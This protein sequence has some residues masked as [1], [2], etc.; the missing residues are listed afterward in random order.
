MGFIDPKKGDEDD[1][2]GLGAT[3]LHVD[4][5]LKR[6]PTCRRELTPWEERCPDC[7]EAGV[8]ASQIAPDTFALPGLLA[9]D[10]DGS[11]DPAEPGGPGSEHQDGSEGSDRR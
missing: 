11:E 9:E 8:A 3:G 2:G 4:L 10:D 5:D 7:G 6:C 1:G